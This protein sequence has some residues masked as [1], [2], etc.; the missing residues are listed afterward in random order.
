MPDD[1]VPPP[2]QP[3]LVAPP[4]PQGPVPN[5]GGDPNTWNMVCHLSAL[6]GCIIPFG[7]LIGPLIVWQIKKDQIPSVAVHGKAALNFQISLMIALLVGIVFTFLCWLSCMGAFLCFLL[8]PALVLI[9]LGGMVFAIIAAI[10]AANG[11]NY[12][13]PW[14]FEFVK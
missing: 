12:Q 4:P 13:Y 8:I 2:I 11:E 1:Q 10:K 3:P 6:A 5:P 9:Q 14:S 7:N